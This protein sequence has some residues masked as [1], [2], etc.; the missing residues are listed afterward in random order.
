MKLKGKIIVSYKMPR[1]MKTAEIEKK[2]EP[3]LH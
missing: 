1:F 3:C 2:N